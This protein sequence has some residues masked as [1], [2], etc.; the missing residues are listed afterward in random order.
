M[1]DAIKILLAI[2]AFIAVAIG[3]YFLVEL[4]LDVMG[5][6]IVGLFVVG[7]ALGIVKG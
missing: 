5:W 3:L 2:L 7:S 1:S 6:V 4:L